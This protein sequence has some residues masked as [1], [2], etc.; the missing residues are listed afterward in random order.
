MD[1]G[2]AKVLNDNEKTYTMCGT[3]KYLP[4]EMIQGSGHTFSA[5][6][7]PLGVIVYQMLMGGE[8]PF[9]FWSDMDDLSLYA[10]IAEADYLELPRDA[11]SAV[12]I[13]FV[14][15]LLVKNPDQRLG[16]N[17]CSDRNE[18]LHHPW[19]AQQDVL[20]RAPWVPNVQGGNAAKYFD[21]FVSEDGDALSGDS[22]IRLTMREQEKFADF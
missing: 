3:P 18:I 1:F 7:W 13:D 9:E 2:Y 15:R 10:S 21:N 19:L 16:S 20:V 11:V 22:A 5:D 8:H 14:D 12:A 17:E 6:Y 4:P